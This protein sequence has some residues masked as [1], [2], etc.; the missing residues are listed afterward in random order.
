[1]PFALIVGTNFNF[2]NVIG[3][4]ISIG[5][6]EIII[7]LLIV[8]LLIENNIKFP[9]KITYAYLLYLFTILL[10]L[11]LSNK[12]ISKISIFEIIKNI[13]YFLL[14]VS[15]Y[16]LANKNNICKS[17]FFLLLASICFFCVAIYQAITFNYYEKRI[18]GTFLSAANVAEESVSNPNVAGAFLAGCLLFFYS[19]K[20][21][22]YKSKII[23]YSLFFLQYI[24]FVL[25]LFTLSR[26][27]F[28]GMILGL[29]ILFYFFKIKIFNKILKLFLNFVIVIIASFYFIGDY[30]NLV[31]IERAVNTFDSSTNSGASVVARF[32]N[33]STALDIAFDNFIFGIGY[34]D[35]E[36]QYNLV[37]D[38][39]YIQNFAETGFL[40]FIASTILLIVIFLDLLKMKKNSFD[41][42]FYYFVSAFIAFYF[43]FLFENYAANLF[44]NPRLLGL[45]WFVLALV[46]KYY[47]IIS[48][49]PINIELIND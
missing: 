7:F 16:S 22:Y 4:N 30:D 18:Y 10:S 14:F 3:I 9:K 2:S 17:L 40:G 11:I 20:R 48:K 34:G 41:N 32:E 38:N 28:I 23:R 43:S 46:Y 49:K 1:M 6:S 12:P 31:V 44:R 37:P 25:I 26:S 24:S 15:T 47:Y 39:F 13:E 8:L 5:H 42:Y 36:N 35:F 27:A 29:I 45:F 33:S 19:F 21:F